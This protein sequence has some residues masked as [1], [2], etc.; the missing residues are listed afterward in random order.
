M[1]KGVKDLHDIVTNYKNNGTKRRTGG[2]ITRT[3]KKY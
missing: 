3:Y 1:S 2:G